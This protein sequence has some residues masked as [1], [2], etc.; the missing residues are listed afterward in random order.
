MQKTFAALQHTAEQEAKYAPIFKAHLPKP[1]GV[2]VLLDDG[3]IISS[4]A[5]MSSTTI[6]ASAGGRIIQSIQ[7]STPPSSALPR[8][9]AVSG[10]AKT[11]TSLTHAD[12][13]ALYPLTMPDTHVINT[14]GTLAALLPY[15][16]ARLPYTHQPYYNLTLHG[17]GRP[18][19]N[20][21]ES[22]SFSPLAH[23]WPM[24]QTPDP[25]DVTPL[26]YLLAWIKSNYAAQPRFSLH[27][28]HIDGWVGKDL[29]LSG[30]DWQALAREAGSTIPIH[31]HG[32]EHALNTIVPSIYSSTY[33]PEAT[34]P[35]PDIFIEYPLA[36]LA[37]T[38]G[39]SEAILEQM[40]LATKDALAKAHTPFSGT[41]RAASVLLNDGKVISGCN[42]QL[43]PVGVPSC[44]ESLTLWQARCHADAQAI[45][46]I[47]IMVEDEHGRILF[48][49]KAAPCGF[50]REN[51]LQHAHPA[52]L[53]ILCDSEGRYSVSHAAA[54][55]HHRHH[56]HHAPNGLSLR[57]E[58]ESG[59]V[60]QQDS[61][62]YSFTDCAYP[63]TALHTAYQHQDKVNAVQLTLSD[64]EGIGAY[65]RS[66][67]LA[68][69]GAEGYVTI[70][71]ERIALR[72]LC[73]EAVL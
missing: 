38:T 17:D 9:I 58:G 29:P 62:S 41:P 39:I 5:S 72:H 21:S 23:G 47:M 67:L 42:V 27:S 44:A 73:P 40:T 15:P 20:S 56:Q 18:R 49:A 52:T 31:W 51:F 46:A 57:V 30:R 70:N 33:M 16:P 45:K 34:L 12:M 25:T 14:G 6:S 10:F 4:H 50:C 13:H 24:L 35:E 71:G 53:I 19:K 32:Q 66:A 2:A 22:P 26:R 8:I 65:L 54:L 3:R 55:L 63:S 36:Q 59:T 37:F 28:M 64:G 68:S 1:N 7:E 69:L 43:P 61:F 11:G 48:G 60:Y